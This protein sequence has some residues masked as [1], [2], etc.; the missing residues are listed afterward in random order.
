[1]DDE[2]VAVLGDGNLLALFPLFRDGRYRVVVIGG[3]EGDTENP[4]LEVFQ[5]ALDARLPGAKVSDPAWMVSFRIHHRHVEQY[6]HGRV[7]IAG[8]AC[9]IH[10]PVGGQGMNTGMQDAYN[11]AW[12]LALVAH[13]RGK[14]E[15]LE[16]YGSERIP[17]ARELVGRTDRAMNA[18]EG[19]IRFH[20]PVTVALRNSLM[21]LVTRL[22]FVQGRAS[23]TLSMLEQNY[24]DGP[25]SAQDRGALWDGGTGDWAAFGH[26][27]AAG[28]RAPDAPL[29]ADDGRESTLHRLFRAPSFQLLLFAGPA[30]AASAHIVDC[31]ARVRDLA[32]NDVAV[33]MVTTSTEPPKG[34]PPGLGLLRDPEGVLHRRYG[35]R[36]ECLY[37]L[38]PDGYVAYRSHAIEGEKVV[39]YLGRIFVSR[40]RTS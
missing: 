6:H 14:P 9:H 8:D 33:H 26:G 24:R 22:N 30:T 18:M 16:T 39:A 4:A 7:F 2:I 11:L 12:K 10:S 13:G 32:G 5:R 35:A 28:E 38:R 3:K 21:S 40:E 34:L 1:M 31:V 15:L 37:L 29:L 19:A 36:S 23:R 27:P 20:H 17:I 25:L